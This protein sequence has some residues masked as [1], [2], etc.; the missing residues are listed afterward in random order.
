VLPDQKKASKSEHFLEQVAEGKLEAVV[1]RFSVH[2][3]DYVTKKIGVSAIVS[4]DDD[5]DSI[6]VKRVEPEAL[7]G[8]EKNEGHMGD[9]ARGTAIVSDCMYSCSTTAFSK[10]F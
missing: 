2:T 6:D 1:T 3:V 4:F 8:S 9:R 5:F 10:R 7:T